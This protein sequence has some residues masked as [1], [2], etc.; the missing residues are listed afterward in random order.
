VHPDL[1]NFAADPTTFYKSTNMLVT[2][3]FSSSAPLRLVELASKRLE[4][5]RQSVFYG[6]LLACNRFDIMDHLG[7]IQQDTLVICGAED[8]MTPVRF[9]Q[10]LTSSIPNAQLRIIPDA[11]HMVML[12]QPHLVAE[13]LQSFLI[14]ISFHP[15]EEF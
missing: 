2:C 6:D 1:L 15:G 10:Y 3:S 4:V 13:S 7:A 5:T 9:A 8:Q 12:E 11:G 14:G